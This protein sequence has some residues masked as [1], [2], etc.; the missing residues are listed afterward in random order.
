MTR[1]RRVADTRELEESVDEF[2]MRG[3]T[4][5]SDGETSTR[6]KERDFGDA[7]VHLIIVAL[8]AWWTFGLSNALYAIYSYVTAE[9]VVIKLDPDDE[10]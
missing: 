3:Y 9:E 4:I 5:K 7:G 6:L 2:V 1:I 10:P 8:T